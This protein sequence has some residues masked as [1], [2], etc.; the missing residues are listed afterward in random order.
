[1]TNRLPDNIAKTVKSTIYQAADE[2]KYMAMSRTDASRFMDG[3]VKRKD[4]G[5]VL[6]NYI[7]KQQ[8]RHYIKDGVLNRYTKI[9]AGEA[10]DIELE[11]IVQKIFGHHVCESECSDGVVLYRSNQDPLGSH[12]VVVAKGTFLKW[13]TALR[14][15][16]CF[17]ASNPF[18][19]TALSTQSLLILYAQ[20]KV[21]PNSDRALL[22]EALKICGAKAHIV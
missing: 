7:Q 20:E 2:A 16:L 22:E 14:K 19:N 18:S 9:K 13:E 12:Y 1:M 15:A 21:I 11:E 10:H 3:L 5:G 17:I 4:I 8:I 6:E